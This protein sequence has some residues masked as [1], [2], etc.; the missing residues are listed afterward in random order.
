[1]SQMAEGE[2]IEASG[3]QTAVARAVIYRF[4]SRCFSHPD[5][6]LLTLFDSARLE[7]FLQSWRYLGWEDS[8]SLAKAVEWLSERPSRDDTQLELQKEYTRLFITAYPKVVAPPYSSVYLD[9]E[10]LVWGQSTAEV[11]KLYEAA[12]LG[13]SEEFHDIPDHIAAELEFAS[14]LI[15]EQQR[16]LESDADNARKLLDIERKFLIEHLSQWAPPFF[17]KVAE[18]S[19]LPF[20][21]EMA[22]L[23]RKFIEA[24]ARRAAV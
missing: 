19:R 6:E 2:P 12:G 3:E 18:C 7:E 10:R 15:V 5:R 11:A 13:I 22:R 8:G 20:Y 9:K 24:D 17:T 4:L 23:A 14:Y 1:M 21:A 16:Q